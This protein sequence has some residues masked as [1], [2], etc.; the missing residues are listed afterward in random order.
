MGISIALAAGA[1]FSEFPSGIENLA[2]LPDFSP[3][4]FWPVLCR[5]DGFWRAL[6]LAGAFT[7]PL[8][9]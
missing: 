3:G 6:G 7:T 2:L 4:A 8:A 9:S 1:Q 5:P